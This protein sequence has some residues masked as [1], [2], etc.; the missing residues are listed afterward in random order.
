LKCF[1]LALRQLGN[2][3]AINP[4]GSSPTMLQRQALLLAKG[5][6]RYCTSSNRHATLLVCE[7]TRGFQNVE[8]EAIV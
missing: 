6:R 3:K 1:V 4:I 8:Y 2:S 5:T 7:C